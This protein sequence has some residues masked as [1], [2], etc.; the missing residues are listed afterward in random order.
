LWARYVGIQS[1]AFWAEICNGCHVVGKILEGNISW[2]CDMYWK[3]D[4]D[5][6]GVFRCLYEE[7]IISRRW[8]K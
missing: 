5:W 8:W 4:D 7:K 2:A 3:I 6:Q 1:L